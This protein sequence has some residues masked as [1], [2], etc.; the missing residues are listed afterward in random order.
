MKT[1]GQRNRLEEVRERLLRLARG[2]NTAQKVVLRANI[3]LKMME[4]LQKKRIAEQLG[5]TRPTV[6][7]WI[8][9]H[10][11]EGIEGLQR[12]ASR[13]GR[14]PTLTEEKER[15]IVESTL[16]G[17]PANATHW[18][19]RSMAKAKGVTRWTVHEVWKKYNLK[20]HLIKTFKISNDPDFVE[21]VRDI[22][23]LYL[24]P[25]DRALVLSVDEKSQIQGIRQDTTRAAHEEGS[26]GDN[27]TRL[28][29]TWDDNTFCSIKYS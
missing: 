7:L 3:I 24:N 5:T 22:V 28:Q 11:E 18:S 21:K 25:P 2:R 16:H 8:K 1:K 10:E 15:A 29:K 9:R 14:K 20:P 4:G 23:G 17:K 19:I 27:D 6:Y 12:D 13:S 26:C